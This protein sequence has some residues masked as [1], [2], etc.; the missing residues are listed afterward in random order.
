MEILFSN[1]LCLIAPKLTGNCVWV[2]L[3]V[4]KMFCCFFV[5]FTMWGHTEK[6]NVQLRSGVKKHRKRNV[7]PRSWAT[8][9]DTVREQQKSVPFGLRS[10]YVRITFTLRSL[11]V[12]V[13]HLLRKNYVIFDRLKWSP[14]LRRKVSRWLFRAIY[15]WSRKP[16]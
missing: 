8:I 6:K 4:F 12:Q 13:A 1:R 3:G 7:N 16:Y 9:H 15:C 2:F 11:P 5:F 10:H 14:H